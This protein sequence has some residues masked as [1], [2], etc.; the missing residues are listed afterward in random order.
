M[1]ESTAKDCRIDEPWFLPNLLKE[2][3]EIRLFAPS[4][5]RDTGQQTEGRSFHLVK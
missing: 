1:G 3:R 4:K 5:E 2:I